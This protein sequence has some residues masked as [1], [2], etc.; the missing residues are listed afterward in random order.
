MIEIP[1]SRCGQGSGFNF[2]VALQLNG[3][4]EKPPGLDAEIDAIDQQALCYA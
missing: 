1:Q 2:A 4:L 3:R